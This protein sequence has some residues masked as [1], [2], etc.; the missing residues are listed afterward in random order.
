M[1]RDETDALRNRNRAREFLQA[2]ILLSLQ[3]HG[4]FAD[5]AFVGGT[6]LRFLY[7]LPRY[8]EDLDFSLR[9]PDGNSGIGERMKAVKSELAAEAYSVEVRVRERRAV[10][11]A[12]VR[13]SGLLYELGLSPHR[14][15]TLA[16]KV[17]LDTNPPDGAGFETRLVRKHYLLN[18]MPYDPGSLFAG[19]LHAILVR[20]YTKGR[21]LYDLLWYTGGQN[22]P[23][24]NTTFLNNALRQSGWDGPRLTEKNWKA[25]VAKRLESVD[26]RQARTD[27]A[28]FLERSREVELIAPETFAGLLE[29]K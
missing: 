14:D 24:P 7:H 26:W 20:K 2:R 4:A 13:F 28:P 29:R 10:A 25:V 1:L 21:D 5:W 18:L 3:D 8:S 16:V 22:W 11:A 23:P 12:M 15:E 27:V 19:K 6:A 9:A 17:E